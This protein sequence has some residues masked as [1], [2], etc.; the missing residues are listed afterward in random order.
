MAEPLVRN[1][2]VMPFSVGEEMSVGKRLASV[3]LFVLFGTLGC[4]KKGSS[5]NP[6]SVTR[7]SLTVGPKATAFKR[8]LYKNGRYVQAVDLSY[9]TEKC[10]L[11]PDQTY[12]LAG[13]PEVEGK[14]FRVQGLV[15]PNCDFADGY[16]FQTHVIINTSGGQ[17]QAAAVA[18]NVEA[19]GSFSKVMS[20]ILAVEGGCAD[21]PS[22]PGGRTFRG[23][24][25]SVAR[26]YGYRG[27]VCDMPL[28]QILDIYERDYYS[29]AAANHPWPLDL[30]VMNTSVNSGLGRAQK[31][32]N[33]L[34]DS[35]TPS[36]KARWFVEQQNAFYRS[37]ADN[38]CN[39]R[40]FLDGWLNRSE[41][42]LSAIDGNPATHLFSPV[43][44]P[45]ALALAGPL[46]LAGD[47]STASVKAVET[48]D[49]AEFND[50]PNM[51]LFGN[52]SC[53]LP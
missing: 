36:E 24:T 45:E 50:A 10:L 23:I 22:D 34:P 48:G 37:L 32:L 12:P 49:V 2:Q 39:F 42:M 44:V 43:P 52:L 53:P 17:E 30:A 7:Y 38:N 1:G 28:N 3:I 14:H 5:S 11:P 29:Q 6:L 15:L 27:D 41:Y 33:N 47:T 4:L 40:V 19:T 31:I 51:T 8:M 21:H 35:G 16:V 13:K 26:E 46:S 20:H 9:K 25:T 18:E